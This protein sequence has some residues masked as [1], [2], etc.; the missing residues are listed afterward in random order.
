MNVLTDGPF[1]LDSEL[2]WNSKR[3]KTN[4]LRLVNTTERRVAM[5]CA[6]VLGT[7]E[8]IATVAGN[9]IAHRFYKTY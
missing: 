9:T 3:N 5:M 8:Q 7:H 4:S 1:G 2:D 6:P